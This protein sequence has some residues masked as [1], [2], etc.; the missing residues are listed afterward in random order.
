MKKY[1]SILLLMSIIGVVAAGCGSSKDKALNAAE[2]DLNET[3]NDIENTEVDVDLT[4]LSATMVY[5]EVYHMVMNPEDYMGKTVKVIGLY[6]PSF[7]DVTNL[8][9]HY[10][11]VQDATE[12]CAQG[13]E[14][15]WSGDHAYPNDFP[16]EGTPIEMTGVFG[17]YEELGEVYHYLAVDEIRIL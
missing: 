7:Y 15:V 6:S 14:F 17:S 9:Y 10:V 11:L 12:C 4:T 2:K 16:Q 1:L 13:L 3:K 8:Y 5:A